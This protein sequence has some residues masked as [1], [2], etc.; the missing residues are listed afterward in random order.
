MATPFLSTRTRWIYIASLDGDVE[1][2]Q[3]IGGGRG[4]YVYL[5]EGHAELD[6]YELTTGDAAK[7]LE[8]QD[9]TIAAGGPSELILVDVPMTFE[10]VGVWRNYL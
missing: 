2:T 9:L 5:I 7:V 4:V 1:V 6:G 8:K 3:V 10:P